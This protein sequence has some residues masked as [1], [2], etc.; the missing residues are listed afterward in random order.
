MPFDPG[1]IAQRAA[2]GNSGT[3]GGGGG[4]QYGSGNPFARV[5]DV[6][7]VFV[8]KR[9]R[10]FYY[11]GSFTARNEQAGNVRS[12]QRTVRKYENADE[13]SA[14]FYDMS[15]DE[16]SA[17]GDY[18]VK[19][20]A[21]EESDKWDFDVL[22]KFW[23]KGVE[24]SSAF[25]AR[26]RDITP[27]EALATYVGWDGSGD[28]AAGRA[29]RAAMA[30]DAPFTGTR[31]MRSESINLSDPKS[32]KALTNYV[33]S[34]ALGREAND[35]EIAQFREA[36]N[37]YETANPTVTMSEATYKEGIQTGQTSKTKS[38]AS[39]AGAEQVL[40]DLARE[41]PDYAEYQAAGP[42]WNAFLAALQSP[43][44]M[45]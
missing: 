12:Q 31:K 6:P 45:G 3:G 17:W 1:A 28:S 14:S 5:E 9:N 18:L 4:F 7:K 36:L 27:K 41:E 24:L 26:G 25:T 35:E 37:N 2:Q 21:I 44:S 29:R 23:D 39:S 38:G 43:V 32:A 33:L 40:T 20:G 34:K 42:I 22:Q 16:R 30:E 11:P 10:E 19:I 15:D 8:G 13:Y